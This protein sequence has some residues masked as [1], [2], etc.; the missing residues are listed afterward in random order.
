M[1][2]IKH[3][4]RWMLVAA[5]SSSTLSG[6]KSGIAMP[7]WNPF[8]KAAP[9]DSNYVEGS[10]P[11]FG[12]STSPQAAPAE[13]SW[14]SAMKKLS[15]PFKSSSTSAKKPTG[16]KAAQGDA[17]SLATKTTP[18]NAA[19][20]VS[21][22]KLQERSNNTAAAVEEYNKALD[23]DPKDLPAL[24]GLARLYDRQGR[25]DEAIKL[26]RTAVE[27]HPENAAVMNDYGL[28]LARSSKIKDSAVALRR[29]VALDPEKVLYRNNLATVLVELGRDDEAYETLVTAHGEAIA[30]YN[31]GYLLNKKES[32]ESKATAYEHFQA[33]SQLKP[34]FKEAQQWVDLLKPTAGAAAVATIPSNPVETAPATVSD[35]TSL[36]T[37]IA[38]P[39][40][41]EELKVDAITVTSPSSQIVSTPLYNV[42]STA[43]VPAPPAN[44]PMIQNAPTTM[45]STVPALPASQP[46]VL[47]ST[48]AGPQLQGP[49]LNQQSGTIPTRNGVRQAI[50][51]QQAAGSQQNA[52]PPVVVKPPV[53]LANAA[54]AASVTNRQSPYAAPTVA[55]PAASSVPTATPATATPPAAVATNSSFAAPPPPK[56]AAIPP[57]PEQVSKLNPFGNMTMDTP[58]AR[59]SQT[60]PSVKTAAKYPA[61]RY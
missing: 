38:T 48:N 15:A 17:I 53:A 10:D 25:Y 1:S 50:A 47:P 34:G 5:L 55:T 44:P 12:Q 3:A 19:L 60:K 32:P 58:G 9:A 6:C 52:N 39:V 42:P 14:N 8:S 36:D 49:Q 2:R 24:L 43:S 30:H 61:S 45:P 18:P 22:A 40:P 46:T 56:P 33:A 23:A 27:L 41:R 59:A 11:T 28:C 57:L 37:P 29:A 13:S 16:S 20:Y 54:V 51:A 7:S 31:V 21:L 4:G 26:Y 35:S